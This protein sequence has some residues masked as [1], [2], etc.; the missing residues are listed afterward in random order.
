[1]IGADG[2]RENQGNPY[3]QRDLMIIIIMVM[4]M[5]LQ[6]LQLLNQNIRSKFHER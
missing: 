1:M 5:I 3:G 4:I 2:E 6:L